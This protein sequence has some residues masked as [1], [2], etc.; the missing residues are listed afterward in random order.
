MNLLHIS[1]IH[2]GP[3]H[4]N[5]DDSLLVTRLNQFNADIILNTGDLTSDSLPEEFQQMQSFLSQLNCPNIVSILG[6]H[7]KYSK[8]SH[9]LFRTYIYDGDFIEPK[10]PDK[11][12]KA[13]VYI[14]SKTI[15]LDIHFS[16]INYFRSFDI[17]GEKVLLI[18]VDST[19]FQDDFGYM[20]E[21][22]IAAMSDELGKNTYQRKLLLT[23]HSILAT[24]NDPLI[25]SKRLSDFVLDHD[26]E[27]VFCGHT[28]EL[29]IVSLSDLIRGRQFRQFMCGSLSSQNIAREANMFC[30]YENFGTAQE[31]IT[32]TR[33]YPS[34]NGMEFVDTVIG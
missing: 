7:D 26:I 1:D 5:A 17:N 15:N 6:N 13:K 20:E 10:Y 3:Y 22:I 24:D 30:T 18:C 33:I 8:R 28:H 4:W 9:E 21:Q 31:I 29:D 11:V 34:E 16:E 19:K 12:K 27:A 25:N 23:H 2:F 32:I 14:D